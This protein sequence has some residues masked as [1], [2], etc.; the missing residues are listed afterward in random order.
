MKIVHLLLGLIFGA[1][2]VVQYND[3]D[4]WLWVSW[5]LLIAAINM[6]AFFGKF[7][8]A[9][10]LVLLLLCLVGLVY[11]FPSVIDW[12]GDSEVEVM[13]EMSSE[14]KYIEEFREFGGV[15]ISMLGLGFCWWRSS[16]K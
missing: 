16:K 13:S 5:Y 9:L 2:A 1:F 7:N 8:Q 6:F 10:L 14:K 11:Y 12:M 3:P 15:V 4:P